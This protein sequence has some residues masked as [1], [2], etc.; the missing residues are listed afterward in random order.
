MLNTQDIEFMNDNR[1]EVTQRRL[2][3]LTLKRT[4]VGEEDP[5][6]GNPTTTY[7]TSEVLGT[8]MALTG[9][10]MGGGGDYEFVDGVKVASGDVVANISTEYEVEGTTEVVRDGKRYKVRAIEK[11]GIGVENRYFVLLRRIT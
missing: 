9:G 1:A 6:T 5:Y 10:G 3:P 8:W 11:L 2:K 7:P 4:V